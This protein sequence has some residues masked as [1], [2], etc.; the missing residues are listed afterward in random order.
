MK[1]HFK[2]ALVVERLDSR[3]STVVR[4][5]NAI[6]VVRSMCIV[7]IRVYRL[8]FAV[9][10]EEEPMTRVRDDSYTFGER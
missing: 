2:Y 3:G 1:N 9:D 8:Q 6:I 10:L 5:N 7:D 4:I